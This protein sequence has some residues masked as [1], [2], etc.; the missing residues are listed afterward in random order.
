MNGDLLIEAGG[1]E[2]AALNIDQLDAL[3][4]R[5]TPAFVGDARAIEMSGGDPFK[6]I[7]IP[8]DGGGKAMAGLLTGETQV[9]STGLSETIDMMRSGQVRIIAVTANERLPEIPDVPTLA[10]QGHPLEFANWRGFFAAP[11]LAQSRYAAMRETIT[12][13]LATPEFE[14]IRARNGWTVLHHEGKDFYQFLEH[15]ESEIGTL[16]RQLGFLRP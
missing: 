1:K 7:Y 16:M 2:Y 4:L 11:G 5:R 15:Q 13:V 3:Q 10:E 14:T 6:V 12:A 8:Y 9:L